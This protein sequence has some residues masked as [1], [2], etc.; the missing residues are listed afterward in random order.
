VVKGIPDRSQMPSK[1][2]AS[3]QS[4]SPSSPSR[5]SVVTPRRPRGFS[6]RLHGDS[7]TK[8]RETPYDL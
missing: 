3:T 2:A 1:P 5:V 7:S 4:F 6:V 8:V